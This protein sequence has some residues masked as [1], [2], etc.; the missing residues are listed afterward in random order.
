MV[1]LTLERPNHFSSIVGM[2]LRSSVRI[3]LGQS[4]VQLCIGDTFVILVLTGSGLWFKVYA[5]I[6]QNVPEETLDVVV[7]ATTNDWHDVATEEIFN[8]GQSLMM[9]KETRCN[10]FINP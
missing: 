1:L 6:Y 5:L 4:L 8:D 2:E 7:G 10:L 3:D 9:T